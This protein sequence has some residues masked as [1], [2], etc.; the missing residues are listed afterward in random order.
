[1]KRAGGGKETPV[2]IIA[3][4]LKLAILTYSIPIM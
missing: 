3:T 2:D 4:E 1:M